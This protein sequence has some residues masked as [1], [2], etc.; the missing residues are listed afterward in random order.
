MGEVHDLT[1]ILDKQVLRDNVAEAYGQLD[2]LLGQFELNNGMKVAL[3]MLAVHKL[4]R[5]MLDTIEAG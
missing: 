3:L 4:N 2:E 1:E 5:E